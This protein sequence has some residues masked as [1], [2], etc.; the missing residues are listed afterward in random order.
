MQREQEAQI[1]DVGVEERETA[2]VVG[3]IA[4]LVVGGVVGYLATE[5]LDTYWEPLADA[6][7]SAVQGVESSANAVGNAVGGAMRGIASVFSFG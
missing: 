5:G 3:T 1:R 2:E 4:G 7:G 6:V